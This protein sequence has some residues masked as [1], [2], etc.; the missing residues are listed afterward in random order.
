MSAILFTRHCINL[1]PGQGIRFSNHITHT[2]CIKIMY[3]VPRNAHQRDSEHWNINTTFRPRQNGWHFADDSFKF[4][5]LNEICCRLTRISAKVISNGPI[6][7]RPSCIIIT[8]SCLAAI[9]HYS[10]LIN[11]THHD[12]VIK[13]KH[14]RVTGPLCGEFTGPGEFPA[15]RPVTRCFDVFFHLRLNKRLSKQPW[16]WWFETAGWSLWRHRNVIS[17]CYMAIKMFHL[18]HPLLVR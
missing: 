8:N 11:Q 1:I 4:I 14:F 3:G 6:N 13:W 12:D 10:P 5:F 9:G 2:S 7:T 16:G 17:Y 15:Q 18:W